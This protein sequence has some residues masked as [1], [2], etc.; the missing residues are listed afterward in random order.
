MKHFPIF[1]LFILTACTEKYDLDMP[2]TRSEK[3]RFS[4]GSILENTPYSLKFIVDKTEKTGDF[5][6]LKNAIHKTTGAEILLANEKEKVILT[7]YFY[8]DSKQNR[9]TLHV[10]HTNSN[11]IFNF[12]QEKLSKNKKQWL[13]TKVDNQKASI[14]KESIL[15][16]IKA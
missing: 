5:Q 14:I 7:N 11:P 8:D 16:Q 10:I 2:K 9:F 12:T 3:D 1:L 4:H 6:S 15:N 13:K